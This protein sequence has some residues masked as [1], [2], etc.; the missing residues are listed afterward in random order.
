MITLESGRRSRLEVIDDTGKT[1]ARRTAAAGA[2]A[3]VRFRPSEVDS[4]TY[5]SAYYA[6]VDPIDQRTTLADWKAASGFDACVEPSIVVKFRDTKDLGY[7]RH[8]RVCPRTPGGGFAAFV[9][10]YQV[11]PLPEIAYSELNLDAVLAKDHEW[12]IG[13]NAIE[14][15]RP[16]N[17]DGSVQT[18]EPYVTKFFNFAP[19]PD[20]ARQARRLE[21]NLDG[22]GDKAM[23][24]ICV[25]CH[26]G[27]QLP[28]ENDGDLPRLRAGGATGARGDLDA[29][30]QVLEV[31]TFQFPDSGPWSR[32]NQEEA[33][34]RINAAIQRS[35]RIGPYGGAGQWDPG[36][37][38]DLLDGWYGGDVTRSGAVYDDAY[39]PPGWRPDP[40]D[41]NPPA[42]ADD[43]FRQ[44]IGPR[45]IVCH[46]KR[47]T[48]LQADVTFS[49]WRRFSSHADQLESLI[50]D[51]ALMPAARVE[52]ER[53]RDEGSREAELLGGFLPGFSH[54]NADGGV[55]LP[56]KAVAD[57]GPD[58]R[59]AGLPVTLSGLD[60][61]FAEGYAWEIVS[62]PSGAS[63]ERPDRGLAELGGSGGDGPYR[64]RLTVTGAD[65]ST[66]VDRVRIT[67]DSGLA[68]VGRTVP[69]P[70]G[71]RF[72]DGD[73]GTADVRWVLQNSIDGAQVC[74]DCHSE[75][76]V[77]S[78]AGVPVFWVDDGSAADIERPYG[79]V[80]ARV[81][82]R[83][84][85][86]SPLLRKPSGNRHNGG[87]R[88]GFDAG[89]DGG[90]GGMNRTAYDLFY[91]WIA[92]GA[93]R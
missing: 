6:A 91:T 17:D 38:M 21:S 83:D 7:G 32:P 74:A 40:V 33:L 68:V 30:L 27:R 65:G 53:F 10:N 42:G 63:L 79:D 86:A 18:G 4:R 49:S 25:Q 37:V 58:R 36:F 76:S 23:P 15:S 31:D 48:G 47:G 14:F 66:D 2:T 87:E 35:Y 89:L 92:E 9:D 57:A 72:D 70:R 71:L 39:L 46:G 45:C 60:S 28:L 80:L 56:G 59:V 77:G 50:Y 62:A 54:S 61:A 41:G 12:V 20:P 64:L 26:G 8:M 82:F 88:P 85:L 81:D 43:L 34:R 11:D 55:E 51:E 29:K 73:A 16:Q 19:D 67:V 22:R 93:P 24:M 44:V 84:P 78:I 3:G 90:G 75:G 5:A 1:R 69:A 52:F 13:T